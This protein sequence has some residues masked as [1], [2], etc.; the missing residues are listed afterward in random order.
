MVRK[1]HKP[2]EIITTP[3]RVEGLRWQGATMAGA[4]RQIGVIE[5][6]FCRRRKGMA[7]SASRKPS[8]GHAPAG[9]KGDDQRTIGLDQPVGPVSDPY[10]LRLTRPCIVPAFDGFDPVGRDRVSG[11]GKR[12][13][14]RDASRLFERPAFRRARRL[15]R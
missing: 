8:D 3:R 14:S 9:A 15:G 12:G 10:I 4:I 13:I 5:A 2:E 11:R 7:G 6:M 1:R